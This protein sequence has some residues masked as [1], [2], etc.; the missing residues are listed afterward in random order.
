[1]L[2][3]SNIV[4]LGDGNFSH[5]IASNY[6]NNKKNSAFIYKG[7]K[8]RVSESNLSRYKSAEFTVDN[9]ECIYPNKKNDYYIIAIGTA[10]HKKEDIETKF[11]KNHSAKK[12][13]LLN[14]N[15]D[16]HKS[17]SIGEGSILYNCVLCYDCILEENVFISAWC[18]IST[19][20]II[21][22]NSSVFARTTILPHCRV[23]ANCSIGSNSFIN[24][25][26]TIGSNCTIAPGSVVYNDIPNDCI[27][28][29]GKIILRNLC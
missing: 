15:S 7:K 1:M 14:V 26:V 27:Y 29:N 24:R 4:L 9:I 13:S 17:T 12:I 11:L 8:L 20:V 23:G 16:I 6:L 21:G 28:I 19:D 10:T 22:K 2:F 3:S 18:I 5:E 25:G